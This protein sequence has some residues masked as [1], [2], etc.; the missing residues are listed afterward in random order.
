[1][2][3]KNNVY[4]GN[5]NCSEQSVPREI[6]SQDVL[7]DIQSL[8]KKNVYGQSQH[9]NPTK[10]SAIEQGFIPVEILKVS[11]SNYDLLK[12]MLYCQIWVTNTSGSTTESIHLTINKM[13]G[14][15]SYM[16]KWGSIVVTS[17]WKLL[18]IY[19]DEASFKK[20]LQVEELPDDI[21]YTNISRDIYN[22]LLSKKWE[23]L[24]DNKL[25]KG[26]LTDVELFK[27]F[28]TD[29]LGTFKKKNADY[30]NSF[31]KSFEK[32]GPIAGVVRLSDKMSRIES[33][34]NKDAQVKSE[35]IEDT[36]LDMA[37]Y[38]IM[39]LIELYKNHE[40]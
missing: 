2:E 18:Y 1:M 36:L 29:M 38:S 39:L 16:I 30:G 9:E 26:S 12:K 22:R 15:E 25:T 14:D 13:V 11:S 20:D 4:R 37:N 34:I 3:E 27:K 33:L 10:E 8:Y 5:T 32:F 23:Q 28:T 17:N 24:Q 7:N 40:D 21:Y 31:H 19:P 35:S 6:A